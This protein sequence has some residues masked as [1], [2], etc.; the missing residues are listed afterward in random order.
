M[1]GEFRGSFIGY[2]SLTISVCLKAMEIDQLNRSMLS[3]V[4]DSSGDS[5][6]MKMKLSPPMQFFTLISNLMSV[7]LY[8]Q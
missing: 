8:S 1:C 4:S 6:S 7:L 3:L 5:G 2:Y